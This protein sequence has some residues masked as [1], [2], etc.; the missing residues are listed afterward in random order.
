MG[1]DGG[2]Q[3]KRS[4]RSGYIFFVKRRREIFGQRLS[5]LFEGHSQKSFQSGV[6][7]RPLFADPKYGRSYFGGRN[8]GFRRH[9]E[10]DM[11]L[12][13]ALCQ[14]RESAKRLPGRPGGELLRHLFLNHDGQTS[15]VGI[16]EGP[17]NNVRG[18]VIGEVGDQMVRPAGQTLSLP[19]AEDIRTVQFELSTFDGGPEPLAQIFAQVSVHLISGDILN[20]DQMSGQIT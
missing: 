4:E 19:M 18:N 7:E 15:A 6:V 2:A 16:F 3:T 13:A 1:A 20:L 5:R 9:I 12:A 14:D 8:E 17:Q 10:A 11:C